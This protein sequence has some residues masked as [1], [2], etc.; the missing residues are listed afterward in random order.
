M[1]ST[2]SQGRKGISGRNERTGELGNERCRD[3]AP[4]VRC[5]K[6]F[7]WV[8]GF[9]EGEELWRAQDWDFWPEL[10]VSFEIE[11]GEVRTI[12]HLDS[13]ICGRLISVVAVKIKTIAAF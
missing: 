2:V 5:G 11:L 3:R 6:S 1:P 10:Q 7:V 9:E 12:R 4:S 13:R 8:W